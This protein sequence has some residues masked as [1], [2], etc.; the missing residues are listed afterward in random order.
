M[1]FGGTP[2]MSHF[3]IDPSLAREVNE[4]GL[5]CGLHSVRRPGNGVVCTLSLTVTAQTADDAMRK[6][7][8]ILKKGKEVST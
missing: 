2:R 7:L 1:F 4:L 3:D 5:R 8:E 6:A